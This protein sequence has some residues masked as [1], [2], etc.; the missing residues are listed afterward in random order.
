MNKTLSYLGLARKASKIYIGEEIF[1]QFKTNKISLLFIASD[2]SEKSRQRYL[3]K[4][5]SYNIDYID[6]YSTIE[7]S[8]AIGKACKSIAIFDEGFTK[9]IKKE[10]G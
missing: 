9:A 7:L 4:C 3:K 10:E 2:I 5:K 6:K 1:D 8:Q